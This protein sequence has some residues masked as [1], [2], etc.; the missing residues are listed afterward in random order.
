VCAFERG[1]TVPISPTQKKLT[2]YKKGG[3][4]KLNQKMISKVNSFV[5]NNMNDDFENFAD[6]TWFF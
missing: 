5:R 6:L 2:A 3:S 1:R 4:I